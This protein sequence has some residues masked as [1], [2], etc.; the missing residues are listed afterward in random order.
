MTRLLLS[1]APGSPSAAANGL[2]LVSSIT[3]H[4]SRSAVCQDRFTDCYLASLFCAM[5]AAAEP[6]L[7]LSLFL[8]S[9]ATVASRPRS[10][11]VLYASKD[12][13]RAPSEQLARGTR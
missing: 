10:D 5:L 6:I 12:E 13:P 2:G 11:T 4:S 8:L 3:F 7:S 1:L 9:D